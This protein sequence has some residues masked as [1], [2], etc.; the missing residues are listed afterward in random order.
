V[1]GFVVKQ[2][3][4]DLRS[5][6]STEAGFI[7]G[8]CR[9]DGEKI[10]LERYQV[11]HLAN[12]SK[13]RWISKSRQIGFSWILA[14]EALA[15]C[16]LR[17][18]YTSIFVS[19]S[20]DEAKERILGARQAFEELPLA[21]QKRLVV[22]SKT[23]LAFDS[24]SGSGKLSRIISVPSKPP[25]GKRGDV[26]L[27]EL[28]HYV[29]DRT[30]YT[31]S[32]ALILRS[33]GQLTGCSTPLGRRGIFWEIAKEELRK[34]PHHSRQVVPWWLCSF[35]CTDVARAAVEAPTLSTEEAVRQFG[36]PGIVEQF[37]SL[38]LE[39]FEEEFCTKFVDE[40]YSYFPY[41]LILPCTSDDVE[42][43]ADLSDLP[44]P[45]GR[46]VAGFDVARTKDRSA[47]ALFDQV[48]NRFTCKLLKTYKNVRFDEQEGELRRLLEHVPI[49]RLSIDNTGVGMHLAENLA[50]DYPQ[51]VPE[52]FSTESKERWC[53]Q[54]KL[55]LQRQDVA[56][57]KDRRLV[58]EL[59]SIKRRVLP[60]GKVGFDSEHQD[61]GHADLFWAVALAVQQERGDGP[62]KHTEFTV[63][64]LGG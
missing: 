7:S 45:R 39:N 22:D 28:A 31:G 9:Q 17:D 10:R 1:T 20:Q 64:I 44:R 40:S 3:E 25:R 8:L 32:T 48:E 53:T 29:H 61:G 11:Q 24:N 42:L 49:S 56:L 2:T 46:Y 63:R 41:N 38:P 13:F 60:S 33:Q 27:D 36:T 59:H 5:F 54:L 47:L 37:D 23:E 12:R 43:V 26:T 52:P 57:P 18:G 16:H 21:Y 15:R 4:A 6:L 14:L 35:F 58:G 62:R 50:R 51:V 34:Y 19:Y 55:L 30:V